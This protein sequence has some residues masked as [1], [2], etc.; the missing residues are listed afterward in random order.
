[1]MAGPGRSGIGLERIL[2]ELTPEQRQSL[3]E[4]L[5]DNRDEARGV[6]EKIRAARADLLEMA[7]ARKFKEDAFRKK[8]MEVAKLEADRAVRMAKAIAELDPP[9]SREQVER[10]KRSLREQSFQPGQ[11]RRRGQPD[12]G[13]DQNDLPRQEPRPEPGERE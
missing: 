7:L 1:M 8:A 4:A 6:E 12:M 2:M 9:L 13:R 3:R 11:E 5:M 10:I